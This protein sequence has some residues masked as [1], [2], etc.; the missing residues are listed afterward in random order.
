MTTTPDPDG[1][2]MT[3]DGEVQ[4]FDPAPD[5]VPKKLRTV[6]YFTA[7][8]VAALAFL[9]ADQAAV[10]APQYADQLA[11]S[12]DRLDNWLLFITAAL[13]VAYRPTR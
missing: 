7:L 4:Q 6:V 11:E 13:G 3:W 2:G 12:W 5:L 1:D 8:A 9:V 10:W